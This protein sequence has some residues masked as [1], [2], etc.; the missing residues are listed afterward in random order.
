MTPFQNRKRSDIDVRDASSSWTIFSGVPEPSDAVRHIQ[1]ICD[2]PVI[3]NLLAEISSQLSSEV[4]KARI[5]SASSPHSSDWLMFPPIK[6]HHSTNYVCTNPRRPHGSRS[7]AKVTHRQANGIM[8]F[9][10]S[11]IDQF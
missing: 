5:L 4:D 10:F 2:R 3:N 11:A 9:K 1:K 6:R 7:V 8:L